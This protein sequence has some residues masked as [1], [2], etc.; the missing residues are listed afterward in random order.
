VKFLHTMIRVKNLERSLTFF[1]DALGLKETKRK[2]IPKGKF[3][4]VFLATAPGEAEIELTYN[5]EQEEEYSNGQ[6]FGH[7]AF[8]VENIYKTCS[9]L[10]GLGIQILRP[11]RDGH[12]AFIKSPDNQSIELLQ[13]GAP[14]APEAPWIEMENEGSW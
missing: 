8:Q 3:T 11:P 14:L 9:R 2:D 13:A 10:Q 7:L 12:M 5:W 1:K 4:L 6:N